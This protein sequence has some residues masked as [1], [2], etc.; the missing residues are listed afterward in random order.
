MNTE[1]SQPE[2]PFADA[3][4]RLDAGDGGRSIAELLEAEHHSDALLDASVVLLNEVVEIFR[5]ADLGPAAALVFFEAFPRR[6]MRGLITVERDLLRQPTL[7]LKRPPKERFGRRD[8][9]LGP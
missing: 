2:L 7:S 3:V 9:P 1:M 6:P 5:R 4:H 8:I